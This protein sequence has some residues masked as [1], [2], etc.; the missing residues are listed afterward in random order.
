MHY[1]EA[2]ALTVDDAESMRAVRL[3]SLIYYGDMFTSFY[4]Q[5]RQK[6]MSYWRDQC[7]EQPDRCWFGLFDGTHLVGL[8]ATRLWEESPDVPV[9]FWWGNYGKPE[10]RNLGGMRLLYEKRLAWAAKRRCPHIMVYVLEGQERPTEILLS[11]GAEYIYTKNMSHGGGPEVPWIWMKIP[12]VAHQL[13]PIQHQASAF[14][15]TGGD[16]FQP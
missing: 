4:N 16:V 5:E 6:P 14:K 3:E 13:Q 10:I 2:K 1:F 15:S 11:L 8:Q 12:L 9:A 7:T